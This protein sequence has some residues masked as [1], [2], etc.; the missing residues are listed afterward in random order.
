MALCVGHTVRGT[1]VLRSLQGPMAP[2]EG[3]QAGAGEGGGWPQ[4]V[5]RQRAQRSLWILPE[6]HGVWSQDEQLPGIANPRHLPGTPQSTP[7]RGPAGS[8]GDQLAP[9]PAGPILPFPTLRSCALG[10]LDAPNRYLQ[11]PLL[12][13]LK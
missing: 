8:R 7:P 2:C 6:L 4:W 12:C 11:S 10:S 9:G 5:G 13:R 1:Q 3:S